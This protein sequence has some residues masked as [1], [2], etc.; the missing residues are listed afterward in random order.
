M[1]KVAVT[2]QSAVIV[3]IAGCYG[4]EEDA[5]TEWMCDRCNKH[6][7]LAV[8]DIHIMSVTLCLL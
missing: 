7:P 4:V 8:R 3:Y 2:A 5:G 1:S 6:Q